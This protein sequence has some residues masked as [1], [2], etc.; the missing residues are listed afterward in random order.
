MRAMK[1]LTSKL[2]PRVLMKREAGYRNNK[3][4][5]LWIRSVAQ[6]SSW[7]DIE[8]DLVVCMETVAM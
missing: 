2:V 1:T 5:F 7:R 6:M 4:V 3:V 8:S